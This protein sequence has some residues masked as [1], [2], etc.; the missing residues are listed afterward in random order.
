MTSRFARR[1]GQVA[2]AVLVV[3]ALV[4]CDSTPAES[5]G[6]TAA[7][8]AATTVTPPATGP[9]PELEPAE[10]VEGGLPD[11]ELP[12]L[13]D[14]PAVNLAALRGTPLV[15][16]VWAAWCT[17]CD[18]EMPLFAEA[19]DRAGDE[20]RFFGVHYKAPRD[21]GLQ[22]ERDFGVPF[23]SVHDED[24][25]VV[26]TRLGAYAPP[27]TF[28]V[29]AEGRVTGRQIGEITSMAEMAELM[30]RHLGVRL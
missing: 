20:V 11:L 22:S 28:F 9:C 19:A 1:P 25:D 8:P 2:G 18:R 4:S 17:N 3:L 13:G 23:P 10:P 27:Q 30:R 6:S 21:Y 5:A 7:A 12:C 26:V 29:D 15:V 16:N 14:G 24:G